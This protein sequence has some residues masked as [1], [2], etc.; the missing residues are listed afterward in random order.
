M[1]TICADADATIFSRN[2]APPPPLMSVRS[3]AISSAPS[4]VRSKLGRLIE[5]GKRY[6][7]RGCL[8]AG[9]F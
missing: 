8:R 4:T 9:H 7:G 6:A 1:T 2:K 5:G 3:G